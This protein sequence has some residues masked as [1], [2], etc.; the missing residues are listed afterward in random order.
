MKQAVASDIRLISGMLYIKE[1]MP[2]QK[3]R[4]QNSWDTLYIPPFILHM[5]HMLD[6]LS[7]RH[8]DTMRAPRS[9]EDL[10][11]LVHHDRRGL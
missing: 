6:F 8:V 5:L 4:N 1:L 3:A 11:V 9:L 10:M 2:E 7:S